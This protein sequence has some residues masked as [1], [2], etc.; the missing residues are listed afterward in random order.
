[1]INRKSQLIVLA[2]GLH[3]VG[4]VPV[5]NG[6]RNGRLFLQA[7]LQINIGSIEAP[8]FIAGSCFHFRLQISFGQIFQISHHNHDRFR[9]SI[10]DKPRRNESNDH[11]QQSNG[12]D[13]PKQQI[14]HETAER[15][16]GGRE[17]FFHIRHTHFGFLQL[18]EERCFFRTFQVVTN[19][20]F[21]THHIFVSFVADSHSLIHLRVVHHKHQLETIHQ[22]FGYTTLVVDGGAVCFQNHI[23]IF[24]VGILLVIFF[25]FTKNLRNAC[26]RVQMVIRLLKCLRIVVVQIFVKQLQAGAVIYVVD[27]LLGEH[28][29]EHACGSEKVIRGVAHQQDA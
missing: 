25:R 15:V 17:T 27:A 4:K 11:Q 12:E 6:C 3:L 9:N 2:A 28:Q 23:H 14:D 10:G 18:P 19:G 7:V 29:R 21:Y 5:G 16:D 24:I 13:A 8:D 1:M 22:Q 26:C 20:G